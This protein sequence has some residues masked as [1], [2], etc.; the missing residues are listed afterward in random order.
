MATA[1]STPKSTEVT[2]LRDLKTSARDQ[3]MLDPRIIQIEESFNPRDYS[4][5]E[6]RAH[7]DELKASIR[8]NGVLVPLLVRYDAANKAAVLVDGECRLRATLE[9]LAEGVEILTVPTIQVSNV[10]DGAERLCTALTANTGKPLSKWEAGTA[11]LRLQKYGWDL[12]AIS[13]KLGYSERF[14]KEAVEL[15]DAPRE[16]KELLSMRAVTPSLALDHIRQHGSNATMTLTS[17]VE[18]AHLAGQPTAK[19]S[20]AAAGEGDLTKLLRALLAD[21]DAAALENAEY[22]WVEVNRE[23]LAAIAKIV[24]KE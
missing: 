21:V 1:A 16:V 5:P 3:L 22:Q 24:G 19:R 12:P 10:S 13:K 4:L 20:K 11:F 15:A 23:K 14:I 9:L 17:K 2:R 18:E 6:N 7:L 8:E